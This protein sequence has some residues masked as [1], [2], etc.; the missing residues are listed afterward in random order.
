MIRK[1]KNGLGRITTAVSMPLD[2]VAEV[3]LP[4]FVTVR[5]VDYNNDEDIRLWCQLINEAYGEDVYDEE[6]ARAL[7]Q[8]HSYLKDTE[9][10]FLFENDLLIG[11]MSFGVYRDNEDVGGAFR[12][13]TSKEVRGRGLGSVLLNCTNRRLLERGC[14][15][16]ESQI[17]LRR[18]VSLNAHFKAGYRPIDVRKRSLKTEHSPLIRYLFGM[19]ANAKTNAISR[20]YKASSRK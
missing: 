13:A 20:E 8:N 16:I 9:T 4:P 12:F 11:T 18:V 5:D 3:T 15:R 2:N 1:I 19:Y 17:K 7:L 10:I 6:K 14:V